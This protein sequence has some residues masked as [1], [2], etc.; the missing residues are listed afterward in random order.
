MGK[1]VV[2]ALCGASFDV[3]EGEFLTILGPSGSGKSTLLHLMGGL[4]R[5]AQ[6]CVLTIHYY[7]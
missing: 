7:L 2:P 5:R 1:I 3:Q 6:N 4:D